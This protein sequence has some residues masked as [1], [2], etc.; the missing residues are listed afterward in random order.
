MLWNKEE[1]DIL[2]QVI[3]AAL[4]HVDSLFIADDGSTDNSWDII[5][6]YKRAKDKIEHIQQEPSP[7]DRSQRNALL[8]EMRRQ[9]YGQNDWV[10]VIES[11]IM[12]LDTS[13]KLAIKDHA[14]QDMAV[15]WQTLNAT[16]TKEAWPSTDTWPHWGK[17]LN[18]IMPYWHRL[19]HMLYTFRLLPELRYTDMWRPWPSGFAKY[20][21]GSE[22]KVDRRTDD[23][24]LLAHFGYR[25]PTHF[26]NKFKNHSSNVGGFH[27]KYKSWDLRSVE[28]VL[29]TVSF[30]NGEYNS[31]TFPLSREGWKSWRI[32]RK[33]KCS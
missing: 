25:G 22:V 2:P 27:K 5:Q 24:P 10:Q 7:K 17:P 32:W 6:A 14:V 16:N 12:I 4:P 3:E 11:D 18:E 31:M 19:E 21:D 9:G 1:A 20:S 13:P 15:S 23:A 26:Y 30:F 33:G 29:D 8:A 28:S